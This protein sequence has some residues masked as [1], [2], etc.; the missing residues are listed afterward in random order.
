MFLDESIHY[1]AVSPRQ[2]RAVLVHVIKIL[3]ILASN[4]GA[5]SSRSSALVAGN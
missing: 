2:N 5:G 1:P 3:E 4:H